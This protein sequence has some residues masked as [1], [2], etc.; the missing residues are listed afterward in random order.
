MGTV[1]GHAYLR[2]GPGPGRW[3]GAWLHGLRGRVLQQGC[4]AGVP[5]AAVQP[6]CV[7]HRA[8]SGGCSL[9]V[10]AGSLPC[11]QCHHI[12]PACLPACPSA[13]ARLKAHNVATLCCRASLLRWRGAASASRCALGGGG[14]VGH[15]A[16]IPPPSCPMHGAPLP[17]LP[18]CLA[19]PGWSPSTAGTGAAIRCAGSAEPADSGGMNE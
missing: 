4:P 3:P 2:Q 9:P 11:W 15:P 1:P 14:G 18:Y 13:A 12:S 7:C 17:R 19:T 16:S 6:A 8:T 10:S 5:S